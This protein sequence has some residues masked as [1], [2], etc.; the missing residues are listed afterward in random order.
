MQIELQDLK[1]ESL[2]KQNNL[3]YLKNLLF[4]L[5]FY[6]ENIKEKLNY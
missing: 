5:D 1:D 6:V 4:H 3:F 2:F